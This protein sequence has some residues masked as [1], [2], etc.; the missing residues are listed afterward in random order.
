M[1]GINTALNFFDRQAVCI[2][3]GVVGES[4]DV[5]VNG[6]WGSGSSS[7]MSGKMPADAGIMVMS[8]GATSVSH[9][10]I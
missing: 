3:A 4:I 8:A 6:L 10:N 5:G 2:D 7:M 9:V 1:T